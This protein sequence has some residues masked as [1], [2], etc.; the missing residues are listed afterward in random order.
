MLL[1]V[2]QQQN[3]RKVRPRLQTAVP[4][5]VGGVG[6]VDA[7]AIAAATL[8]PARMLGVDGKTGSIVPGKQAD[9]MLVEGDPSQHMSDL[10]QTRLVMLGGKLMDA[11]ALRSAAGFS[12][13]PH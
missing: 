2:H 8:V 1:L 9:L 4:A 10:R 7:D 11:D 12:G 5:V 6:E 3:A 13:R